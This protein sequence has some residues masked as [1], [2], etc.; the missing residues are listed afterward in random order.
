M[1]DWKSGGS[2]PLACS[3]R[4]G[5]PMIL[6]RA[7]SLVLSGMALA[8]VVQAGPIF[9]GPATITA[10]NGTLV[11]NL[12]AGGDLSSLS[13]LPSNPADFKV[14][15]ISNVWSFDPPPGESG[16]L[17]LGA[18]LALAGIDSGLNFSRTIDLADE[19]GEVIFSTN[20]GPPGGLPFQET[21][22]Q[23]LLDNGGKIFGKLIPNPGT[24]AAW[25]EFFARGS[26]LTNYL[27]VQMTAADANQIPEPSAVLVWAGVAAA[28]FFVHR[29]SRQRSATK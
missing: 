10:T 1:A 11:F 22:A 23:H 19:T 9:S 29:R 24:E 16:T 6:R 8:T 17:D 14:E 7:W 20:P 18:T 5:N 13:E 25:D 21:L 3:S 12:L 28:G 15:V 27:F 4:K 2:I 26:T